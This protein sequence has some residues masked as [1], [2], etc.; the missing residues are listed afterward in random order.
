MQFSFITNALSERN[1]EIRENVVLDC[2]V[3]QLVCGWI[4]FAI[5]RV[6]LTTGR[7][8]LRVCVTQVTLYL[9]NSRPIIEFIVGKQ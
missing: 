3:L 6:R 9:Q 2:V 5:S 1:G 7:Q 4:L 8:S